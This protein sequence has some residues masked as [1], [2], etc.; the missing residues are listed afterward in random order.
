MLRRILIIFMDKMISIL[1]FRNLGFV[2]SVLV[3]HDPAQPPNRFFLLDTHPLL[4][5]Q[6][7]QVRYDSFRDSTLSHGHGG[8]RNKRRLGSTRTLLPGTGRQTSLLGRTT[9]MPTSKCLSVLPKLLPSLFPEW[10]LT[11]PGT[12]LL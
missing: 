8:Q 6:S 9:H 4:F 1:R 5:S 12:N 2:F 3:S 10:T 7:S 11:R